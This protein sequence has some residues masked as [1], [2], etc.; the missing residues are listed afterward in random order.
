MSDLLFPFGAPVVESSPSASA[1]RKLY[2]L[3]AFPS[4]LHVRWAGSDGTKIGAL[5]VDNEPEPFWDGEDAEQ[6]VEKWKEAINYQDAWGTVKAAS[7]GGAGKWL[8]KNIMSPL[9]ITRADCWITDCLTTYRMSTGG[10]TAIE[11]RFKPFAAANGIP[12]PTLMPHPNETSIV[13]QCL[14]SRVKEIRAEII[15]CQPETIVTLGNSALRVLRTVVD[16]HD[17]API[18][19]LETRYFGSPASATI[20]GRQMVWLPL[21]HSSSPKAQQDAHKHWV[22]RRETDGA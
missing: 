14:A 9:R 7:N 8:D 10:T 1:P 20:E 4:A 15:A 22:T 16:A 11:E 18:S 2:V 12:E 13:K 6:R 19:G 17:G 3:G 21:A 5:P